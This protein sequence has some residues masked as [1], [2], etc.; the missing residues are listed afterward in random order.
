MYDVWAAVYFCW[1]LCYKMYLLLFISYAT[2]IFK[3]G[4]LAEAHARFLEITFIRVV[5]PP[6]R[7]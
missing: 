5:C 6:L 4:V 2:Y 7:P 1:F 3:P